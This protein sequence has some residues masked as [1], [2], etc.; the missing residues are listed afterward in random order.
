DADVR[1]IERQR[2]AGA[3][4]NF[5]HPAAELVGSLDRSITALAEDAAEHQVVNRSPAVIGLLDH[6]AVE[7][8][9]PGTV[10]L[11]RLCHLRSR[12]PCN[13]SIRLWVPPLAPHRAAT[14]RAPAP[15]RQTAP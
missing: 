10:K 4:A 6:L 1:P 13:G 5:Q 2:N 7:V 14:G 9:L 8:Q 3:D 11:H 15:A 12:Y